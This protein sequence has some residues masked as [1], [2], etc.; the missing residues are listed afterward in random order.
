MR[1]ADKFNLPLGIDVRI[2]LQMPDGPPLSALGRVVRVGS[3]WIRRAF[4]L[5]ASREP[6]R[7]GLMRYI[8]D[9]EVK[10]LRASRG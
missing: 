9:R 7:I 5:T 10:A 6:T 8:R 1:I 2:V 3:E 4:A